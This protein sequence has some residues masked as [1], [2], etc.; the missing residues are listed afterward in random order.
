MQLNLAARIGSG[1]AAL[2]FVAA[3]AVPAAAIAQG[4]QVAPAAH[5]FASIDANHDGTIDTTEAM[6]AASAQF[7]AADTDHDGTLTAKELAAGPN[8]AH[9]AKWF[10]RI[11]TDNDGTIS[12][13]EYMAAVRTQFAKA[14]S[15]GDGTVSRTEWS[16]PAARVLRYLISG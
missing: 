5:G 14:D 13:D 2:M 11:D 4:A 15:D 3:I 8:G 6:Q 1:M 12:K 7:D 16:A 9:L 10:S